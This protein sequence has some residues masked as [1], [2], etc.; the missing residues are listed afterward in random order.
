MR[1]RRE[2]NN[3]VNLGE[4]KNYMKKLKDLKKSLKIV[5]KKLESYIVRQNLPFP[6]FY[7]ID[8]NSQI[9]IDFIE[10]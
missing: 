3:I 9:E 7:S 2:N 8:L 6:K 5:H 4:Y 10:V 1:E